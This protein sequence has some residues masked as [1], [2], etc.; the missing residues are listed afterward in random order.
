[1]SPKTPTPVVDLDA[2][3]EQHEEKRKKEAVEPFVLKGVGPD[4]LDVTFADPTN[5]TW[6]EAQDVAEAI[7][8]QNL[9]EVFFA[10]IPDSDELNAWFEAEVP[11]PVA[12]EVLQRWMKHHGW[13]AIRGR[14]MNREDRR[15][16]NKS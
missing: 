10:I 9:R 3:I 4:S 15:R 14:R 12:G 16:K 8:Q 11:G 7:A 6:Q 1:M 5:F 2:L 13:D